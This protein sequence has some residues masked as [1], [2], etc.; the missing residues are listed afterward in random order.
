MAIKYQSDRLDELLDKQQPRVLTLEEVNRHCAKHDPVEISD[1]QPLYVEY[2][3]SRPWF[4]HWATVETLES[5]VI[6]ID[7]RAEYGKEWRCWTSHP[8]EEQRKVTPRETGTAN[9]RK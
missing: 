5:W 1:N 4:L 9:G 8:T 7:T 2:K 3:N 6:G